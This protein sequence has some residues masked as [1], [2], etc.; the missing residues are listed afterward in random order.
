[1]RDPY[2]QG[3]APWWI[4]DRAVLNGLNESNEG[5]NPTELNEWKDLILMPSAGLCKR[6]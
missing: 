1:M 4:Q 3:A 6:S 2:G 5:I